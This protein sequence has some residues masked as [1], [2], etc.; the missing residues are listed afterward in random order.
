MNLSS[1]SVKNRS[2][3]SPAPIQ[4]NSCKLWNTGGK[5]EEIHEKDALPTPTPLPPEK[6]KRNPSKSSKTVDS[7]EEG[8]ALNRRKRK[9]KEE[10]NQAAKGTKNEQKECCKRRK[11]KHH[12]STPPP[13]RFCVCVYAR[14]HTR[15]RRA[16]RMLA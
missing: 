15:R 5:K 10:K 6:R 14:A 13:G 4:T 7:G 16:F 3:S 11:R 9:E 2:K 1:V 8:R 12:S